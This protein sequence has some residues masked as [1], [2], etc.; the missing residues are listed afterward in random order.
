MGDQEIVYE[1]AKVPESY[2][3]TPYNGKLDCENVSKFDVTGPNK[4]SSDT[5]LIVPQ[6]VLAAAAV[7]QEFSLKFYCKCGEIVINFW[8]TI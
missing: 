5:F 8:S 6:M 3:V 2:D 1:I 4:E 7:R